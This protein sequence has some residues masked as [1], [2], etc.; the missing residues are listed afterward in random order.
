M[1]I[2]H[3]ETVSLKASK[4][5]IFTLEREKWIYHDNSKKRKHYDKPDDHSVPSFSISTAKKNMLGSNVCI[6]YFQ[7]GVVY[8][9]LLSSNDFGRSPVRILWKKTSEE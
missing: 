5:D 7:R 9:E 4:D 2:F 1:L 8:F 6:W 3:I